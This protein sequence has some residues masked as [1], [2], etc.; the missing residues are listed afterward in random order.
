MFVVSKH[1]IKDNATNPTNQFIYE[2]KYEGGQVD[3]HRGWM[4]FKKTTLIDVQNKT[5]TITDFSTDFPLLGMM[6]GQE[7]RHNNQVLGKT[8]SQYHSNKDQ[9]GVYKIWKTDLKIDYYTEQ[10]NEKKLLILPQLA[11]GK[12][13]IL[14]PIYAGKSLNTM[15]R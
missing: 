14:K 8:T 7:I 6:L 10:E 9:K 3:L 12:V 15:S 11:T 2:H 4:G 13:G 5:E 1:R